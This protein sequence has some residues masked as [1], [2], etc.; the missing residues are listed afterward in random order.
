MAY[1]PYGQD[2][3]GAAGR[4]FLPRRCR[5]T[6]MR[7]CLGATKVCGDR[8]ARAAR[9]SRRGPG[10]LSVSA[11]RHRLPDPRLRACRFR[12]NAAAPSQ[13]QPSQ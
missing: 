12:C 9:A 1:E 6:A 4:F 11:G 2:E 5:A 8:R 10:Q 13:L 3:P 7:A